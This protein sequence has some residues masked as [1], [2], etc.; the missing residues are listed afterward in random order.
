[1][2]NNISR[3]L[4]RRR[5]GSWF[6]SNRRRQRVREFRMNNFKPSIINRSKVLLS[7]LLLISQEPILRRRI[8]LRLLRY[9]KIR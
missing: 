4:K 5:K 6:Y 9:K 3:Y 7:L 8:L 2:R 1:L